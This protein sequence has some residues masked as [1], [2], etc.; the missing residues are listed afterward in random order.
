MAARLFGLVRGQA[1]VRG[2]GL[3][4]AAVTP[5]SSSSSSSSLLA[6]RWIGEQS[7]GADALKKKGEVLV[8]SSGKAG[9]QEILLSKE[10]V[11]D[12]PDHVKKLGDEILMLNVVDIR[13]LLSRLQSRLGITDDQLGR[14]GGGGGGVGGGGGD[15]SS[16]APAAAAAAAAAAPKDTF[17]IKL[18]VVDAKSKIKVIK[19][20]RVIT[21]LGL[22]ES[23]ALV[24]KAPC[25]LKAGVK[26]EE[27][28]KLKKV[29]E[30]AGASVDLE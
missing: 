18:T 10:S 15:A 11:Q 14:G 2:S 30:E 21:G 28:E 20:V 9:S 7:W 23:K 8:S 27:A 13:D 3:W 29:L 24:E 19:E 12:V 4:R 26:K 22:A 17:D 25:M 16:G 6:R 1:A 5:S